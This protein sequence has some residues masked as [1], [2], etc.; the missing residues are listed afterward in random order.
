M[1]FTRIIYRSRAVGNNRARDFFD[2][3]AASER[4]NPLRQVTGFLLDNGED[5]LQYLEGPPMEVEALLAVIEADS[6]HEEM[7]IIHRESAEERLLGDWSMKPLVRLGG[8]PALRELA[9]LL[10]GRQGGSH[11]LAEVERF[12]GRTQF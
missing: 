8:P 5:F 2:I 7:A 12:A 1:A 11:V 10:E 6:R 3:I 9:Q 4:N